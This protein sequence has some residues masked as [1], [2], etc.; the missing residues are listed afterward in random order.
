MLQL[1]SKL[2]AG[3]HPAA[4][5]ASGPTGCLRAPKHPPTRCRAA[6]RP[7]EHDASKGIHHPATPEER[8]AAAADT[9]SSKV[10]GADDDCEAAASKQQPPVGADAEQDDEDEVRPAPH[11]VLDQHSGT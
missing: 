8:A 7:G 6:D 9:S 10:E 3:T 5:H 1:G 11:A 2:Q 4:D